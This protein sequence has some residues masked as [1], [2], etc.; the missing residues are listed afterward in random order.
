VAERVAELFGE[1]AAAYARGERPQ[2]REFLA[3]AGEQVDE[4]AS[5]IDTL[6]ALSLIHQSQPP[7]K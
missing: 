4:Q 3:R 7:I 5:L 2:S 1:Y 6:L